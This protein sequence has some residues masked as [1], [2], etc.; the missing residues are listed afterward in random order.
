MEG[1]RGS[2]PEEKG[3]CFALTTALDRSEGGDKGWKKGKW[4]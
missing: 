4:H 2:K 3:L 1:G